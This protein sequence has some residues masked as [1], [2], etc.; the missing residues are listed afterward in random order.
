MFPLSKFAQTYSTEEE[1]ETITGNADSEGGRKGGK[2][3][4]PFYHG[5]DRQHWY[6]C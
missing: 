1:E 5:S 4:I 3:A 6:E 2:S